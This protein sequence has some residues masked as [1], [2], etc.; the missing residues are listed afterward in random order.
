MLSIFKEMDGYIKNDFK[1]KVNKT[2]NNLNQSF[3]EIIIWLTLKEESIAGCCG[4][5]KEID[6]FFLDPVYV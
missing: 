1:T 5:R 6:I 3:I 4:N 2:W